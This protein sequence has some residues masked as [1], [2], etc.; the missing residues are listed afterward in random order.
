M[1][2]ILRALRGI[3]ICLLGAVVAVNAAL[4][5]SR[6][7]LKQDP[8]HVFGF[9]P[10]LVTTGSMEPGLPAG[11]MVVAHAREDYEVGEVISFRQ[12]GGVITH[13]IIEKTRE[14]Y[15]TAGD[16]NNAPDGETVPEEAVLGRVEVCLPW[17]GKLLLF[18]REPMGILAL[19]AG[20]ALLLL[21]PEKQGKEPYEDTEKKA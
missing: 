7:A 17:V 18:L 13:R 3:A 16:A 10:M 6:F 1:K 21:L 15:R 9:Y 12:G 5:F 2:R 4:L 14:G 19:A 8:A 11:A 20:G